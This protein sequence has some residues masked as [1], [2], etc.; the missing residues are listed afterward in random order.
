MGKIGPGVKKQNCPHKGKCESDSLPTETDNNNLLWVA[1][2]LELIYE[3]KSLK[4]PGFNKFAPS[5]YIELGG[6]EIEGSLKENGKSRADLWAFAGLVAVELAAQIHNTMCNGTNMDNYCGGQPED[7]GYTPC[8]YEIPQFEFK[9]GRRD[10]TTLCEG[11]DAF[12]GFCSSATVLN[13]KFPKENAC[14][15]WQKACHK[16]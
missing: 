11:H 6:T 10:C 7:S 16:N 4:V 3:D 15:C 12:Y 9:H 5:K 14:F 8:S 13:C 1:R 2:V